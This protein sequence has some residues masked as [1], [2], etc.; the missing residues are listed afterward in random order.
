MATHSNE[1]YNSYNLNQAGDKTVTNEPIKGPVAKAEMLIRRPVAQVFEAFVDPAITAQFWFSRGSGR[2]EA[3]KTVEW[4]WDM[5][6]FSGQVTVKELEKNKR[7][8]IE[9]S[10]AG[11]STTVEWTFVAREDETT[12]VSIANYGFGGESDEVIAQ[13]IGST[14]GFTIVLAG[15]KAFL[16]H[17][18]RLNLVADRF[19]P[20]I[21]GS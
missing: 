18:V 7:I 13:A 5:Y 16:E 20:P 9:W 4:F 2:L 1:N 17:N 21:K 12:F 11:K 8:R 15:L 19:P 6:N 3:G 14:E 10:A